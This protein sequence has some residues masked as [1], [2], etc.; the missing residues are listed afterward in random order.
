MDALHYLGLLVS[1]LLIIIYKVNS[2]RRIQHKNLPPSPP[3]VPIIGHFHLLIKTPIHQAL[4]NFSNEYGPIFLLRLG[5]RPTLVLSSR[6]A[7]EECFPKNDI[8]FSNRPL[9]PSRKI[10]EYN[11]T[12]T[13][14]YGDHWRMW[15]RFSLI[16]IFSKRRL[17]MSSEFRA[18]EIRFVAKY[19]YYKNYFKGVTKVDVKSF[20]Y[21]LTFNMVMKMVAG[22]RCFEYEEL[23][24]SETNKGKLDDLLEMFSPLV[25]VALGDYFPFLRWL[26]YYGEER[27]LLKIHKKKDTFIQ[28]LIDAHQNTTSSLTSVDDRKTSQTIIGVMLKLKESEPEFYTN[29]LIKGIIQVMLLAGTYSTVTTMDWV[30]S[31]LISHPDVLKNARD[32]IDNHVGSSRLMNNTD[33]A[34]LPYLHCVITE[35]LRLS[36]SG[37]VELRESSEDCTVGEYHIPR[38]TQLLVDGRHMHRDP[39]LWTEPERFKPERFLE[40]EEEKGMFKFIIFGIGRRICPGED[41]AMRIMALSLGTLIQCFDWEEARYES[42]EGPLKTN[43]NKPENI[44]SPEIVFR[45][46]KAITEVL[47]QL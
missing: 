41:L 23:E 35:T 45:P 43:Q 38:G 20:F 27:R 39:E 24:D 4:T 11:H 9:L 37:I 46:R 12:I 44:R 22:K 2:N 6:A 26:T 36:Q 15:R 13:A 21:K 16:E 34:K 32:E 19:L 30:V 40:S 8:I 29:D 7:I 42:Q 33:L 5:S 47:A 14:P 17:Q 31:R 1:I 10:L 28:A 3:S 18:E 25:N